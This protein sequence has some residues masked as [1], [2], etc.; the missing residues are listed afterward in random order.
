MWAEYLAVVSEVDKLIGEHASYSHFQGCL[1]DLSLLLLLVCCLWLISMLVDKP[2][3]ANAIW[4]VW[5]VVLGSSI[6]YRSP[7]REVSPKQMLL[8]SVIG[9]WSVRLG[10][11]LTAARGNW[12][13]V[14][15][16]ELF[17]ARQFKLASLMVLFLGKAALVTVAC[18]PMYAALRNRFSQVSELDLV[19]LLVML[20]GVLIETYA[21]E[22]VSQ[23]DNKVLVDVGPWLYCRHPNYF[24]EWLFWVGLWIFSGLDRVGTAGP[25]L[26]LLVL[27]AVSAPLMEEHHLEVRREEYELYVQ[28]VPSSF[29][30]LPFH[31]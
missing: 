1:F 2:W 3:V 21:D 4:P 13:Y 17:G 10:L 7:M 25:I 19:G 30:P 18:L 31:W 6:L 22:L 5:P 14:Q 24:G 8:L 9:F 12:Q 26:V 20:V 16:K 29:F 27:F 11:H 28:R 15:L 23:T